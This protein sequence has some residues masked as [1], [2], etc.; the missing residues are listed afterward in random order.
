MNGVITWRG[1]DHPSN[2]YC[3]VHIDEQ[4]LRAV[5]N[6][7]GIFKDMPFSVQYVLSTN[8]RF[9]TRMLLLKANYGSTAWDISLL[10]NN[11]VWYMNNE[12]HTE[13]RGCPDVDI[14]TTPLTNTLPIRRLSLAVGEETEIRVLYFDLFEGTISTLSQKYKRLSE[15][16]YHYENVPND[17]EADIEVDS[18]GLVVNYPGL[19]NRT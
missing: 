7:E 2:E 3:E 6:I 8:E 1:L 9:E 18:K 10:K 11:G 16:T 13:F 4:G 17:F 15:N 19:F 12:P 14:A 5:S